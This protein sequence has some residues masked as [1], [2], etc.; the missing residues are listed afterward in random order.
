MSL[1]PII[2]GLL[3]GLVAVV[4]TTYIAKRV[5]KAGRP[6]ELRHTGFMWALGCAC[7]VLALLPVAATVAGSHKDTLAKAALFL[8]FSLGAIY[9]FGEAAWVRGSFNADGISFRTPWTGM[10]SERWSELRSIDFV[11]SC[12]WYTLSFASGKK[13]RLSQYL[14]GHMAALEMTAV[15]RPDLGRRET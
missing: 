9:C 12:G 15:Q 13:V 14:R 2:S 3:G 8:G 4:L 1:R 5:G 7:L 11:P 10:K 6:G